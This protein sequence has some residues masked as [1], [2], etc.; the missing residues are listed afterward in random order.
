L[1]RAEATALR[2]SLARAWPRFLREAR[3]QHAGMDAEI[4]RIMRGD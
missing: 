2:T 3:R 1:P 4:A